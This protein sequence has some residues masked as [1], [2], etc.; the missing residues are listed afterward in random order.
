MPDVLPQTVFS[1]TPSATSE[2]LSTR[3][4]LIGFFRLTASRAQVYDN[5]DSF[6]VRYSARPENCGNV[7][8]ETGVH[9]SVS[10]FAIKSDG[11]SE[12]FSSGGRLDEVNS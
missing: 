8:L 6:S 2:L 4:R 3:E 11:F 1:K 10:T 7:G 12:A 9:D 5:N